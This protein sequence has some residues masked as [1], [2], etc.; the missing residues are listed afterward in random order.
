MIKLYYSPGACSLASHIVLEELGIAF[1]PVMVSL[2]DGEHKRPEYLRVNPKAKVPALNV[3]GKVLTETVAILT[4]L[5]GGYAERGLWPKETWKQAEALSLMSWLSS[6]VHIAAAGIFRAERFST[7]PAAKES[8]NTTAKQT[9]LSCY[10]EIDKMLVGRSFAM[11]GQYGV[12]DPY[13][14]VFYRWGNRLGIDMKALYPV[15]TKHAQRVFSRP[16]VKRVFEAEG[17]E[18]DK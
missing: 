7:D 9:L 6:T 2:A 18:L 10:A 5:G 1:E 14:L 16:T 11:G 3:D 8:I 17:I 4:Y 15:W 13:L 12:C